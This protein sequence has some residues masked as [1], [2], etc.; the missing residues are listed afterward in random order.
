MGKLAP[1]ELKKLLNCIKLDARVLV[2]P[3][4]GFDAGVHRLGDKYVVVATDPCV[5][6]PEAWFGYLLIHYAASDLALFGAK[7]EFCTVTLMGPRKTKPQKFLKMMKQTCKAADDLNM[8]IVR[9]HTGTYGGISKLVG[10]CTVYGTIEKD[11]LRTPADAKPGDLILCTK[12]IGLETAVNYALIHEGRAQRLFG[13]P[14]T[15]SL[16]KLVPMQSCVKE[17]LQLSELDGLHAM[18]D[19]TEG[20]FIA[21]MNELAYTSKLGFEVE[22]DKLP[23]PP[24]AQILQETFGLSDEQVMA[25]SSTGTI[26]AAVDPQAGENVKQLLSR[27][28]LKAS[29][30]GKFTEN[31][32]R[33]LTKKIKKEVFPLTAEDPYARI[34]AANSDS[35]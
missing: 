22:F 11:K 34:L 29:F 25:M 2:P 28:G 8:A 13:K 31:K 24:E 10:V 15:D 3:Q 35:E 6:V 16:A 21:A 7:P 20:G 9:G 17:A 23:I 14:R 33:Y 1:D 32:N 12:P 26:I 4:V 27:S 30:V 18:H 5:G 19:A